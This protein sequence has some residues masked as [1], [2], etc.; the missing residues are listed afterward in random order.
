MP[1]RGALGPQRDGAAVLRACGVV[2]PPRPRGG[3]ETQRD[4]G[5]RTGTDANT[6]SQII[7]GIERRGLV[8]RD[9]HARDSRALA[10]SLTPEGLE[11]ARACASR[12]RALNDRFFADADP[13]LYDTLMG[14]ARRAER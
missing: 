8:R 7:R 4:I 10:L 11:L 6:A 13:G 12:A 2:A 5:E 14:L 9:P 1:E 3:G